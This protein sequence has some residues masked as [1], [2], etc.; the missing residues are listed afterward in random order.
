MGLAVSSHVHAQV[1]VH[2]RDAAIV[3]FDETTRRYVPEDVSVGLVAINGSAD[4]LHDLRGSVTAFE[5]L[6][7]ESGTSELEVQF[8]SRLLPGDS[9]LLHVPLRIVRAGPSNNMQFRYPQQL[10]WTLV[11]ETGFTREQGAA[12]GHGKAVI[13][14]L[15]PR[16]VSDRLISTLAVSDTVVLLPGED[17]KQE[18]VVEVEGMVYAGDDRQY[19]LWGVHLDL[20]TTMN[21]FWDGVNVQRIWPPDSVERFL[22]TRKDTLHTRYRLRIPYGWKFDYISMVQGCHGM[23]A[24]SGCGLFSARGTEQIMWLR[25]E[26]GKRLALRGGTSG[27]HLGW[28]GVP[29][30]QNWCGTAPA[31]LDS[32]DFTVRENGEVLPFVSFTPQNYHVLRRPVHSILAIDISL[33]MSEGETWSRVDEITRAWRDALD[34]A[35]DSMSVFTFGDAAQL[36]LPSAVSA[37]KLDMFLDTARMRLGTDPFPQLKEVLSFAGECSTQCAVMVT[38]L[39]DGWFPNASFFEDSLLSELREIE[40]SVVPLSATS[41]Y[42]EDTFLPLRGSAALVPYLYATT[43]TPSPTLSEPARLT[44]VIPCWNGKQRERVISV[45]DWCGADTSFSHSYELYN[46]QNISPL[47]PYAEDATLRGG[48]SFACTVRYDRADRMQGDHAEFFITYDSTFLTLV[49]VAIPRSSHAVIH[50]TWNTPGYAHIITAVDTAG[51]SAVLGDLTFRSGAVT[52]TV[53]TPVTVYAWNRH[54]CR[55]ADDSCVAVIT[56]FPTTSNVQTVI[57]GDWRISAVYPQPARSTLHV[58]LTAPVGIAGHYR[59]LDVLG[60]AR[61]TGVVA[62]ESRN[63]ALSLPAG[64]PPGSYLLEMEARGRREMHPF[65]VIR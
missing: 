39:T 29:M 20:P 63:V 9:A 1:T 57:A 6:Q 15:C 5:R 3:R 16:G 52:D 47:F 49:S 10:L 19:T 24:D 31:P 12:E 58:E 45:R 53:R 27:S 61:V 43:R 59:I 28:L 18:T 21:V 37:Q 51:G 8:A 25:N 14:E 54:G 62:A 30:F 23:Y 60:R 41:D 35:R 44:Y 32:S 65:Q 17:G 22:V 46:N 11:W 50:E 2:V 36:A 55:P 38:V 42:N 13:D 33:S 4:T 48:G 64:L 26:P 56:L 40:F 34:P 7:F